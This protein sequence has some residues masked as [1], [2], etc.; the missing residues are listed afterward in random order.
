MIK[1]RG[2]RKK[3]KKQKEVASKFSSSS[4][5]GLSEPAPTSAPS[6]KSRFGISWMG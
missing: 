3:T 2:K 1:F 6:K 4:H 5:G